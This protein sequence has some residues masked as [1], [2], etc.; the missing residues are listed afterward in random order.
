[1]LELTY[2]SCAVEHLALIKPQGDDYK[3]QA[4]FLNKGFH[5]M[6][7]DHFAVS[8]WAGTTCVAAAGIVPIY[9][10]RA[11]AWALMSRD[12]GPYMRQITRKVRSALDLSPYK[13]IEMLV[14]YEFK[15]GHQWAKMLGFKVEA[16]RM[17]MSGV[18]GNDETMY[19]RIKE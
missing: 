5:Y 2:L 11:M 18:Y 14:D 19:V 17:I 7:K 8:A 12:A 1:M 10:H 3:D 4:A 16:P 15:A 13:R 6:V 9:N